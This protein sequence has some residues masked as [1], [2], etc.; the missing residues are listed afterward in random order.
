[1]ANTESIYNLI[2]RAEIVEAKPPMHRSKYPGTVPPT[3]STFGR[4][5]SGSIP[6]T[7]LAGEYDLPDHKKAA[8]TWGPQQTSKRLPSDFVKAR[9]RTLAETLPAPTKFD[10]EESRKPPVPRKS[11]AATTV[12]KTDKNFV[13][14]NALKAITTKPTKKA[15]TEPSYLEKEDFGQ[16]PEYLR[17]IQAEIS[18]EKEQLRRLMNSEKEEEAKRLNQM[19]VLSE[20]EKQEL[21]AALKKKW[22]AI[23][24]Q[25]QG[26]THVTALDTITKIRRKE[27]YESQ[28]SDLE[29]SIEK[30]SKKVVF[31]KDE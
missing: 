15:S 29:K 14:D 20:P 10:Y 27:Q 4:V 17:K 11:E 21:L 13:L 22:E 8:A 24:S 6:V 3:A 31:V 16:V 19:R 7:N 9:P 2:P 26:M 23:N 25:Y 28:L 30:L 12:T 18:A 1:M 5:P